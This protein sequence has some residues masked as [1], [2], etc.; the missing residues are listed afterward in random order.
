L[1]DFVAIQAST[2]ASTFGEWRT[3]AHSDAEKRGALSRR[4]IGDWW[5]VATS[6]PNL[7]LDENRHSIRA[8]PL[9][10]TKLSACVHLEA[11]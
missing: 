3:L 8:S 9:A 5:M 6:D 4:R 7:P 11:R 1:S 2:Q 10:I